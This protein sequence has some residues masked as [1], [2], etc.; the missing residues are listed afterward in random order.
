MKLLKTVSMAL[1]M[2][3][4]LNSCTK[5][6]KAPQE[7]VGWHQKMT[8][9]YQEKF[10]NPTVTHHVY[11]KK[12]GD[13]AFLDLSGDYPRLVFKKCENCHIIVTRNSM[14]KIT[15]SDINDFDLQ[16][17]VG[18][19]EQVPGHT[20]LYLMPYAYPDTKEIRVFVYDLSLK[21]LSEKRKR[22][23]FD[24]QKGKKVKTEFQWLEKP[25]P[26]K[27]QRSDGSSRDMNIVAQLKYELE[28]KSGTLSIYDF[29]NSEYKKTDK[30]MLLYRDYSNGKKNLW[31]WSLF[32]Y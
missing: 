14:D 3:F 25:Q 11:L 18:K 13:L 8:Q 21:S 23:F 1:F 12:D 19:K 32:K 28:N 17:E 20:N 27:I 2:F 10:A 31:S 24:Y 9:K 30:A 22:S 26:V 7:W 5:A 6:E 15:V 4:F 16:I 29:G